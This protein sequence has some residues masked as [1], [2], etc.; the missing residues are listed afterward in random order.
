MNPGDREQEQQWREYG[1]EEDGAQAAAAA[2]A[3]GSAQLC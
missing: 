1:S 3:A 2:A